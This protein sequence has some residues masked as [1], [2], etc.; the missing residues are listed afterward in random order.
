MKTQLCKPALRIPDPSRLHR[1]DKKGNR[2]RINTVGS[3]FCPL[4]HGSRNNG[5]CCG[6][7]HKIKHKARCVFLNK[8]PK[9]HKDLQV[10]NPNHPKCIILCH[11]QT[12]PQH[13]K[14][15]RANTKI[16]QIFHDDIP[17][18]LSSGKPSFHHGKAC[19][20][21]K[22]QG[23]S[24]Q[25]P[26]TKYF[27]G[28]RCLHKFHNFCCSHMH[29]PPFHRTICPV[30]LSTANSPY[31]QRRLSCPNHK[32]RL[33]LYYGKRKGALE[34]NSKT[35]LPFPVYI[36]HL[37]TK[38]V[39]HCFFDTLSTGLSVPKRMTGRHM[40]DRSKNKK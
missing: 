32:R 35:P 31:G 1:I 24:D 26:D 14:H 23:G 5:G 3:K 17:G 12:E 25:E 6:T 2:C 16:H 28:D 22:Y 29:H 10:G 21:E 33:C 30:P 4:C 37:H 27:A 40:P 7:E 11:H 8:S 19:L 36:M 15:C 9:I 18:I 20:H 39:K 13:N 38:F 34:C